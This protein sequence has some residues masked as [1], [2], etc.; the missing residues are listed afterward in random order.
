MKKFAYIIW[1]VGLAACAILILTFGDAAGA[2]LGPNDVTPATNTPVN[3]TIAAT[4]G[5]TPTTDVLGGWRHFVWVS[6][7]PLGA[8]KTQ[9]PEGTSL[10]YVN[11]WNPTDTAFRIDTQNAFGANQAPRIEGQY[12]ASWGIISIPWQSANGPLPAVAGPFS[13]RLYLPDVSPGRWTQRDSVEWDIGAN[14][15]FNSTTYY[16]TNDIAR[17]EVFDKS[18][19][20]DSNAQE[21]VTVHVW[22][23]NGSPKG[24]DIKLREGGFATGRFDTGYNGYPDLTFCTDSDCSAAAS[25]RLQVG[26]N[27]D[28]IHAHYAPLDLEATALWRPGGN[29]GTPGATVPAGTSTPTPT[30]TSTFPVGAQ[31][32]TVTPLPSKMGYVTGPNNGTARL[33]SED[34]AIYIFAG[35]NG[36]DPPAFLGVMEFAPTLPANARLVNADLTLTGGFAGS[37]LDPSP[38]GHWQTDLVDFSSHAVGATMTFSDVFTANTLSTLSPTLGAADLAPGKPNKLFFSTN[39]VN[40]VQAQ[41]TSQGRVV[42]RITGPLDWPF[43]PNLF[44][45]STGLQPGSA[46]A[47]PVLKLNY[48]LVAP[49]TSTASP[50]ATSA[51]SSTATRTL[52]VTVTPTLTP[53]VTPTSPTGVPQVL[54]QGVVENC[55]GQAVSN[56]Q[57]TLQGVSP[58]NSGSTS[59]TGLY[60]IG[61]IYT[62]FP[63][64]DYYISATA[65]NYAP[66]A[67]SVHLLLRPAPFVVDFKDATCLVPTT[68]SRTPSPTATATPSATATATTTPSATATATATPSATATATPTPTATSSPTYTPTPSPTP[69][70]LAPEVRFDRPY[71]VGLDDT[72]RVSVYDPLLA[73]TPSV[74]A[75]VITSQQGYVTLTLRLDP[76]TPH[77]YV[78]DEDISF[79]QD[80]C[81]GSGNEPTPHLRVLPPST[82]ITVQY[83]TGK[84][85]VFGEAMW[86]EVAPP[87]TPTPTATITATTTA[88]ATA[89]ATATVTVTATATFTATATATP[90][91]TATLTAT[92]TWTPSP[93]ASRTPSAT[94]TAT[95]TPTNT[96]TPTATATDTPTPTETPHD[97]LRPFKLY[98]P[99]LSS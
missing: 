93:T 39:A 73:D 4:G 58:P 5:P 46:S 67:Q 16:G 85:Q 48:V 15:K 94:P 9:F 62:D 37:Q 49:A 10:V 43:R 3:P 20:L 19:N 52:T 76:N 50:T 84:P 68:A 32:L 78:A 77:L 59:P 96:V 24:F 60:S 53:T 34:P 22:S 18:A 54:V 47:A 90:T 1:A 88:T 26:A 30:P 35:Y 70:S 29:P 6:S 71:Y 82:T 28:T 74:Y 75:R 7:E 56:A 65:P 69:T 87:D 63:E 72:V 40:A 92:A 80:G 83:P 13:T 11:I 33:A 17:V 51:A 98:L 12:Q 25:A 14:V 27:G 23:E 66:R 57:V 64:A 42:F 89:T 55:Q 91:P 61:P 36:A 21:T 41:I 97:V 99:L 31:T 81:G 95:P 86:Y 79:C 45:W 44:G 2:A 8:P 38:D